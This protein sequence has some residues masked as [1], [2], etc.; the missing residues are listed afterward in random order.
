MCIITIDEQFHPVTMSPNPFNYHKWMQ[1]ITDYNIINICI[2]YYIRRVNVVYVSNTIHMHN[3]SVSYFA[4]E[5][6]SWT[7][8]IMKRYPP[9]SD[10]REHQLRDQC[11]T[12]QLKSVMY[13]FAIS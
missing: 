9:L 7:V 5:K 1:T 12:L 6:N 8:N 2:P 3:A 13:T 11:S 4:H 10:R